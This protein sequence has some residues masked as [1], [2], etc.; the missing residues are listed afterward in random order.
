MRPGVYC[1]YFCCL[2]IYKVSQ[3]HFG[4]PLDSKHDQNNFLS[5]HLTAQKWSC[6]SA[7]V[8]RVGLLNE[9]VLIG[10]WDDKWRL[11]WCFETI[12]SN[13]CFSDIRSRDSEAP[14][15]ECFYMSKS[16]RQELDSC[17]LRGKMFLCDY[18]LSHSWQV[19]SWFL[20][21]HSLNHKV[22]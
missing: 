22:Y 16:W 20:C 2:M 13:K 21:W 10:K 3:R 6:W 19:W 4:Y 8:N 14:L 18:K 9:E 17:C 7:E 12:M 5:Q 15:A 11:S 1:G